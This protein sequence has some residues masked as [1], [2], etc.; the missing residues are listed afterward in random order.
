MRWRLAVGGVAWLGVLALFVWG[1]QPRDRSRRMRPPMTSMTASSLVTELN[2]P[3]ADTGARW[4]SWRVTR[5]TSAQ[6]A[7]LVDVEA[8][9]VADA[10]AIAIQIVEPVRSHG[11]EEILVYVRKSGAPVS[12]PERRIQWTPKGGYVEMVMDN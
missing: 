6:R 1:L 11:Y 4:W 3:Q 2:R 7:M 8:Q 10:R 9:R 5:A 12:R